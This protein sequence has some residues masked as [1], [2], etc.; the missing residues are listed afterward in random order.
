MT[1]IEHT[2]RCLRIGTPLRGV[3]GLLSIAAVT[4]F[5]PLHAAL[6][7][8]DERVLLEPPA[9]AREAGAVFTV[10]NRGAATVRITDVKSGCGCTVAELERTE[11]PP[12]DSAQ[13]RAVYHVGVRHGR[14]SVT[15]SVF[16]DEGRSEPYALTLDVVIKPGVEIAPRLVYWKLGDEPTPKSV[17]IT[18]VEDFRLLGVESAGAEF[19]VELLPGEGAEREVR[20]TPRDTLARRQAQIAVRL[21]RGDSEPETIPLWVRV[22]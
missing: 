18:L 9:G 15:I 22:L 6:E 13:L 10:T 20:I 19:A 12:G 2:V 17:R 11:L 21:A 3:R 8:K 5:A 14:Q 16:T 1:W 7:W 4:L